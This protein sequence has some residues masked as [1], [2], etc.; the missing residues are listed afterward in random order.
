[1]KI[2]KRIN[3]IKE[4]IQIKGLLDATKDDIYLSVTQKVLYEQ[5]KQH[6]TDLTLH[7]TTSGISTE[8]HCRHELVVSMSTHG[9]R[10]HEAY[11]AIE[12]LLQQ[13]MKPNRIILNISKDE[14]IN[15]PLPQTIQMQMLRGLEVNYCEDY[16]SYKKI[17]PT[18]RRFPNA[19]IITA[20]DDC[21][22][23][24]DFIENLLISHLKDPTA[25][26][27]NRIHKITKNNDG[28]LKSYLDWEQQISNQEGSSNLFFFTSVGGVLYPPHSLYKDV[29]RDDIFMNIS[30]F[31]DDVWC[32]A[33]A[34]LQGSPIKKS[35]TH[36]E[37]GNDF[38]S[39]L[40]V[41]NDALCI[42]NTNS[43]NC[44]NDIIIKAV[45]DKYNIYQYL[46]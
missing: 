7:S 17:I 24:Y 43:D 4:L 12:S 14:F 40:E 37:T 36:S 9:I 10:L 8:K 2:K 11:L 31:N 45:F 32:F 1:M 28:T 15:T 23:N 22:Y 13:S 39:V 21:L 27:A 30:K 6:L 34:I 19:V 18:L 26:W 42:E 5:R 35:F 29:T 25:I 20:D 16:L 41:Q 3:Q 38:L 33:M 46:E 44:R